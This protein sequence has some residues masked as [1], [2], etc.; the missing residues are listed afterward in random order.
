MRG[1]T[2]LAVFLIVTGIVFLV[3]TL[4]GRAPILYDAIATGGGGAASGATGG[5][6]MPSDTRTTR[7]RSA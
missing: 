4:R 3:A 1:S 7:K 2:F 6:Q 5:R